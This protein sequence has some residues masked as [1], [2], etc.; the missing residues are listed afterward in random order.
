MYHFLVDFTSEFLFFK[1]LWLMYVFTYYFMQNSLDDSFL[2]VNN[3][4][5]LLLIRVGA[6]VI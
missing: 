2:V 3:I 5:I 4:E 1:F 6:N